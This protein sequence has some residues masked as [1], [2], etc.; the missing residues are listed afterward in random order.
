MIGNLETPNKS[1]AEEE[2]S[3]ANHPGSLKEGIR[4]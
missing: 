2:L 3:M 1:G 4:R